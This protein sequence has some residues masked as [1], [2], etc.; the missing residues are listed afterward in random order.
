[1]IFKSD[2]CSCADH[3]VI[4][5]LFYTEKA[6]FQTTLKECK[7]EINTALNWLNKVVKTLTLCN[8]N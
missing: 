7:K 4:N 1:M 3:K 6:E 5:V 8:K 2:Q